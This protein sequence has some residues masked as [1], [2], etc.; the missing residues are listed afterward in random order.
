MPEYKGFRADRLREAMEENGAHFE[1][2]VN[3]FE[4]NSGEKL[5]RQGKHILIDIIDGKYEPSIND[6]CTICKAVNCS[7]DYLLGLSDEMY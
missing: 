7:A 3:A 4:E 2:I 1:D 5:S 6:L